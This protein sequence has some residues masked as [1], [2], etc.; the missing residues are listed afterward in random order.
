VEKCYI[1]NKG[2]CYKL[3]VKIVKIDLSKSEAEAQ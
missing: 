2:L 1:K 3:K